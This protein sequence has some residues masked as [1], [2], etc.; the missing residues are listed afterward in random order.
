VSGTF[1]RTIKKV[2]GTFFLAGSICWA[3]WVLAGIIGVILVGCGPAQPPPPKEP[4]FPKTEVVQPLDPQLAQAAREEL[5]KGLTSSD[6]SVRDNAIEAEQDT[7]GA[8]RRDDYLRALDDPDPKV[9]FVATMVIG[10]LQIPQALPKMRSM[11]ADPDPVVQIGVRFALHRLGDTTHSHDLEATA[12]DTN[13]QVRGAT[14]MVLGRLHEHSAVKILRPMRLDPHPAVRQTAA[15]ALFLLGEEKGREDLV[16]MTTSAH[17]DD[18]MVAFLAL[19][20]THDQRMREQIRAGLTNDYP[21]VRLVAARG[22]AML[23]GAPRDMG[24]VIA[25]EGAKSADPRQRFLAAHAMAWM[26][27][28][29]AQPILRQLLEDTDPHVR[30]AAAAAILQLNKTK[31]Q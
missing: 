29:D 3:G 25:Q 22:V 11:L 13:P 28:S 15:E 31:A 21:E 27:R 4:P 5:A 7:L 6:A 1:L 23:G 30:I 2:S 16:G 26:N 9:R 14:A 19:A 12:K 18:Q 10:E 8:E 24:F 17:P 20:Q